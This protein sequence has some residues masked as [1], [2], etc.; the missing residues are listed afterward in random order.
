MYEEALG[1][2]LHALH[3]GSV[4]PERLEETKRPLARALEAIAEVRSP[5][6]NRLAAD[7]DREGA[8]V[9]CEKLWTFLRTAQ[10]RG[11]TKEEL[12][13]AF[14]RTQGLFEKLGR[15]KK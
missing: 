4:G 9:L 5:L 11:M 7:G 13:T 1:P 8:L 3:F 15:P 12:A 6:I 2:L 10:E 14:N